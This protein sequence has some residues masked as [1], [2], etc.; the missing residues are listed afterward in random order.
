MNANGN[1]MLGRLRFW[2]YVGGLLVAIATNYAVTRGQVQQHA[3]DIQRLEESKAPRE[4]SA[5]QFRALNERLQ[6]MEN[7]L[8]RIEDR[9]A[10]RNR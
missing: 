5:E 10:K 3:R 8:D 7:K 9:I 1:G 2:L 6:R 4:L